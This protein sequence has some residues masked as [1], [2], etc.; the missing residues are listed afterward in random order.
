[1]TLPRRRPFRPKNRAG[2]FSAH[3]KMIRELYC[4]VWGNAL[5][6]C[7]I[8]HPT[9]AAH[10]RDATNAGVGTKPSDAYLFPACRAHHREQHDI[11]QKA[12]EAR[13]GVNLRDTALNL[14]LQSRDPRAKEAA[15]QILG[16]A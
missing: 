13:Y 8:N 16:A 7:D 4:I 11:G 12:F 6:P 3:R 1:M 9:E 14:A 5:S 2:V 15:K 10:Y